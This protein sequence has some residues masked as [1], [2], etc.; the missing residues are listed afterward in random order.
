MR[1]PLGACLALGL[2]SVLSPAAEP[3][4][5]DA[6]V[7]R[8]GADCFAVREAASRDL[9][10]LGPSALGTVSAAA[11]IHPDPETRRRAAILVEKLRRTAETGSAS[12]A[13]RQLPQSRPGY[14]QY[15]AWFARM[16]T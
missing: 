9:L 6:L 16:S 14:Q 12:S 3:P 8:L 4:S 13:A 10:K 5:A 15:R 7:A 11:T 1:R 2:A